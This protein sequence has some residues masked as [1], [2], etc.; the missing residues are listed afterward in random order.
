MCGAIY[1]SVMTS[2]NSRSLLHIPDT[3]SMSEAVVG[4]SSDVLQSRRRRQSDGCLATSSSH[5]HGDR[6]S[7]TSPEG[8]PEGDE[9]MAAKK[10]PVPRGLVDALS[11]YFTPSDKRRSRVSLNALPTFTPA[12]F[13][14]P[15]LL[16]ATVTLPVMADTTQP[17]VPPSQPPPTPPPVPASIRNWKKARHLPK[18]SASCSVFNNNNNNNDRNRTDSSKESLKRHRSSSSSS[19][20]HHHHHHTVRTS[21]STVQSFET[22]SVSTV[23][24]P[25]SVA[26]VAKRED[27][28]SSTDEET[29]RKR[30][31][32]TQLSALQDSLSHWYVA[33][34]DQRKRTPVVA[35]NTI[36][37]DEFNVDGVSS[38]SD[39]DDARPVKRARKNSTHSLKTSKSHSSSTMSVERNDEKS[40]TA[41]SEHC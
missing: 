6:S 21:A 33:D 29:R 25:K 13:S 7:S 18:S 40:T 5:R 15:P 8:A 11:Q 30:S 34:S 38:D 10:N 12:E 41:S 27:R 17:P 28:N 32:K 20:H 23:D 16:T 2:G 1:R 37:Y 14:T 35:D 4:S 22:V 36:F 24:Q 31:R 9:S 19:H 26:R 3:S 39:L